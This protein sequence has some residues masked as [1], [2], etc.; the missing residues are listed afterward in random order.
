MSADG[1]TLKGSMGPI[2]RYGANIGQFGATLKGSIDNLLR[3]NR[4]C[5]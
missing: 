3:L 2:R 1:R 4:R 5:T